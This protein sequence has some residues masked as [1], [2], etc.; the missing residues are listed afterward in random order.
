PCRRARLHSAECST[1][2]TTHGGSRT[3]A[4]RG[5]EMSDD[6]GVTNLGR[7]GT[8]TSFGVILALWFAACGASHPDV[9]PEDEHRFPVTERDEEPEDDV[10][11][12]APAAS[13]RPVDTADVVVEGPLPSPA[14][15]VEAGDHEGCAHAWLTEADRVTW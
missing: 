7:G 15:W 4:H 13:E 8:M 5:T 1:G 2:L 11:Q 10:A 3:F 6:F 12:G 14:V 9:A